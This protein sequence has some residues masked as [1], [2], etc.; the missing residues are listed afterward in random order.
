MTLVIISYTP[1]AYI[2]L[3]NYLVKTDLKRQKGSPKVATQRD[4]WG[5]EKQTK[6][7]RA[8]TRDCG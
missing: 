5:E 1:Q 2:S 6:H 8:I 3:N 4:F 7:F